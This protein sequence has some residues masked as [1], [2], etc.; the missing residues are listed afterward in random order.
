MTDG[1][2]CMSTDDLFELHEQMV[3]VLRARLIAKKTALEQRM[4]VL[5]RQARVLDTVKPG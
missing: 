4:H 3:M 2:E 5:N 1:W